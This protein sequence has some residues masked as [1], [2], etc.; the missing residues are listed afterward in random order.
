M[1]ILIIGLGSMGKR[2]LR[3]LQNHFPE[4]ILYGLDKNEERRNY[5]EKE[6]HIT[7]F[8]TI[9]EA[10]EKVKINAA[11][12]CTAPLAHHIIIT[13]CL[14][15]GMHIFSELNLVKDGYEENIALAKEKNLKLFLSSTALYRKEMQFVINEVKQSKEIQ[16]YNYHVGQYLPEWHPWEDYNSFFVGDKRTNGCREILAIEMPWI[17]EAFG[18]VI[19]VHVIKQKLTD[20]KID[21]PDCYLIQLLH[22]NKTMGSLVVDVVSREAVRKLEVFSENGYLEWQGKPDTLR[23]KNIDTKQMEV[24]QLYQ[25][26]DKLEDYSSTIIENMYLDEIIAFFNEL[27]GEESSRYSFEKDFYTLEIIDKIEE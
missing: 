8:S 11:F 27:H 22:E 2:R 15:H 14:N 23:V 25:Q 17:I 13:Q 7:T 3:L 20:L 19:S 16:C 18:K 12:I 24:V 9:E 1:N 26:I 5:C 6:Y 4:I 10:A 21:Y